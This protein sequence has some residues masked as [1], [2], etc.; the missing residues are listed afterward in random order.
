[1]KVLAADECQPSRDGVP[2]SSARRPSEASQT[3]KNDEINMKSVKPK[4]I[5]TICHN[6]ILSQHAETK[7]TRMLKRCVGL[8]VLLMAS[9]VGGHTLRTRKG[10]SDVRSHLQ[11]D[12]EWLIVGEG[13]NK[14]DYTKKTFS[15][16]NVFK[17][18]SEKIYRDKTGKARQFADKLYEKLISMEESDLATRVDEEEQYGNLPKDMKD[19]VKG[20]DKLVI[21]DLKKWPSLHKANLFHWIRHF[22]FGEDQEGD[23]FAVNPLFGREKHNR[24]YKSLWDLAR[25]LYGWESSFPNLLQEYQIA[26]ELS[27]NHCVNKRYDQILNKIHAFLENP[28]TREESTAIPSYGKYL[29][30]KI[31]EVVE[32]AKIDFRSNERTWDDGVLWA[33]YYTRNF[34]NKNGP[35]GPVPSNFMPILEDPSVINLPHRDGDDNLSEAQRRFFVK[36]S[37][38]HDISIW[39]KECPGFTKETKQKLWSPVQWRN[40]PAA[41]AMQENGFPLDHVNHKRPE[42]AWIP[43]DA[44]AKSWS[45][46]TKYSTEE[47][48][49]AFL[50]ARRYKIPMWGRHSYTVSHELRLLDLIN[51]YQSETRFDAL[52]FAVVMWSQ[53]AWWRQFYDHTKNL[54]YHT[55]H[56][57]LDGQCDFINSKTHSFEYSLC[58][59]PPVGLCENCLGNRSDNGAY[60]PN[61][62]KQLFVWQKITQNCD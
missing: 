21:E 55:F 57:T 12:Q 5:L 23:K 58:Y 4:L 3:V 2:Y 11:L 30:E 31:E 46:D 27:A 45:N 15:G 28:Y 54:P 33:N 22:T 43:V 48:N 37:I 19:W 25:A 47:T 26:S 13:K 6:I 17:H 59:I 41:I 35:F 44:E 9:V 34:G 10:Q 53:A 38:L 14:T 32:K 51:Q 56:E 18:I 7:L 40:F 1:M 60:E 50:F 62:L 36:V 42:K 61:N 49:P 20:Y 8:T 29:K 16:I 52:D 24:Y 39:F